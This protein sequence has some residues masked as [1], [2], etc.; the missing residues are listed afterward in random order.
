M[1][2]T[3]DQ[4]TV[5]AADHSD[6]LAICTLLLQAWHS[7]G[8]ARWDQLDALET[9]CEALLA[10]RFGQTVGLALLDLRAP[11][12][13]RVSA[14]A[15]SDREE[16]GEVWEQLWPGAEQY[17]RDRG[18]RFAYH[19]G[20]APWLLQVLSEHRFRQVNALVSYE[21]I[22]DGPSPAGHPGVRLR[23]VR[24]ADL[25]A[26]EEIDTASFPLLWRYP[27]P[28]LQACMQSPARFVVAE[29]DRRLVGYELSTQEGNAGQIV[30]LAVLP[31]YRRQGVGSRLLAD[32]LAAFRR[33]SV[34][35]VSLSTQSDNLSAQR[36]YDRF[37]FQCTGEELPVL[38]KALA[39]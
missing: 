36:L 37:G 5:R 33:G 16:V 2:E 21:K 30:R 19:V 3:T 14:V 6:R 22:H 18:F 39:R 25:Q 31:Q 17:L 26:V 20:E 35:R 15:V 23:P 32:A 12:V 7:A 38:E 24:P 10:S 9:G 28:M 13:A 29:W 27:L 8:G 11:P 34:R 1:H 4:L